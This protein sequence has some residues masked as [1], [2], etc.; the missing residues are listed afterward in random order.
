MRE[1]KIFH[2]WSANRRKFSARSG[3]RWGGKQLPAFRLV[4]QFIK[5]LSQIGVGRGEFTHTH[6]GANREYAHFH[7][8]RRSQYV[9]GLN[10]AVLSESLG[11]RSGEFQFGQVVAICD[12]LGLLRRV[13]LEHE[14]AGEASG[15]ALHL[16]IEPLGCH[17]IE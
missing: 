9:G 11:Q 17:P 10:C 15:I 6:E 16:L 14:V 3:M 7:S 12:H 5:P 4:L 2:S 1:E 13:D 8:F